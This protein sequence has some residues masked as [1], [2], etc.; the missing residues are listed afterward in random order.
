MLISQLGAIASDSPISLGEAQLMTIMAIGAYYDATKGN[1]PEESKA[2]RTMRDVLERAC[3]LYGFRD[4]GG[5][6]NPESRA[7]AIEEIRNKDKK[8]AKRNH[9]AE[10]QS[11]CRF[12][13]LTDLGLLIKG[14]P[15]DP[16]RTQEEKKSARTGWSWYVTS[17]L[18]SAGQLLSCS[19]PDLEMFLQ[20]SWMQFSAALY[21]PNA[22]RLDPFADQLEVAAYLDQALPFA[23]RQIG[24]IQLHTWASLSCLKAFSS[25]KVIELDD[26]NKLLLSIHRHPRLSTFLRVGGQEGLRTRNIA[27]MGKS[28]YKLLREHPVEREETD[29]K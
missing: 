21:K 20:R 16:P 11:V 19:S 13:Q 23:R 10:Y 15:A 8:L 18:H 28:I 14:D 22:D 5:L 3:R 9:V 12:E 1:S 4:P 17:A 7:K 27:M 6:L 29:G 24:P 2:R 25:D 26:I